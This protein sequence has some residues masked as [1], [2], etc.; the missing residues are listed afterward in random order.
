[1]TCQSRKPHE[2]PPGT[3]PTVNKMQET[4]DGYV[5]ELMINQEGAVE[6]AEHA[7]LKAMHKE[8]TPPGGGTFNPVLLLVRPLPRGD[9]VRQD[10]KRRL[11]PPPP[12]KGVRFGPLGPRRPPRPLPWLCR[13]TE[14]GGRRSGCLAA[15]CRVTTQLGVP[16]PHHHAQHRARRPTVPATARLRPGAA[17]PG[18]GAPLQAAVHRGPAHRPQGPHPGHQGG[19]RVRRPQPEAAPTQARG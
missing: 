10:R 13:P 15:P 3:R 12:H 17:P 4:V 14:R 7:V 6:A 16:L 8:Y 2:A 18:G 11:G 1:M 9:H 5:L 19:P